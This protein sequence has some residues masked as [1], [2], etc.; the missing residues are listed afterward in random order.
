MYFIPTSEVILLHNQLTPVVQW[1]ERGALRSKNAW[2]QGYAIFR[3]TCNNMS[4]D[5]IWAKE[6]FP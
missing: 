1:E 3:I 6:N 2:H 4:F 5:A